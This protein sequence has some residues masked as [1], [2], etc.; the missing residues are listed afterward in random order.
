MII[1]RQPKRGD[2][3]DAGSSP[4]ASQ[5]EIL[6]QFNKKTDP[7]TTSYGYVLSGRADVKANGFCFDG[8]AGTFF[9]VPGEFELNATGLVVVIS[10]I[11]YKGL[12]SAG[13]LESTGRLSYLNGCSSTVLI[14]PP[15][16]GDPVLNHL[17]I[18]HGV[19]QLEHTHPSIRLGIVV[20][21]SGMARGR[22]LKLNDWHE[23]LFKGCVFLLN[24]GELHAFS[25]MA[26]ERGMDLVTYHPDSEWGPSDD[27]HP[28]LASTLLERRLPQNQD[29]GR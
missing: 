7:G 28:M 11:G 10:R 20:R 23:P 14:S 8:S 27:D 16:L 18:P 24:T 5:L 21:G 17:H 6:T 25:T 2:S 4:N 12:L 26:D 3:L 29:L 1:I 9:S 15:K 22:D 19:D 13:R